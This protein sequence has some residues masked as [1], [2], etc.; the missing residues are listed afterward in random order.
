M[1]T[2]GSVP[3]LMLQWCT[4]VDRG[5]FSVGTPFSSMVVVVV[6]TG[7]WRVDSWASPVSSHLSRFDHSIFDLLC[8]VLVIGLVAGSVMGLSCV[9]TIE[10]SLTIRTSFFFNLT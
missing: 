1:T 10:Y 9:I 6:M 5:S 7:L 8:Y 3:K 2:F 4:R